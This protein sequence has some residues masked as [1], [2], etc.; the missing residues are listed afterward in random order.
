MVEASEGRPVEYDIMPIW[1]STGSYKQPLNI[2]I[3]ELALGKYEFEV[4][5]NTTIV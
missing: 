5:T 2:L 1:G 4:F 3:M